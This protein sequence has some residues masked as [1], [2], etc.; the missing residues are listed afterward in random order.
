[1]TDLTI[2]GLVVPGIAVSA[3]GAVLA[4]AW[5]FAA[6]RELARL[7]ARLG[8]A[9]TVLGAVHPHR[10]DAAVTLWRETAAF[11]RA[12][13]DLL[14]PFEELALEEDAPRGARREAFL[15]HEERLARELAA[16]FPALMRA[17]ASAECF[18]TADGGR[19]V[20]ALTDAYG[21]AHARYW[22]SRFAE[23]RDE[24]REAMA[25]ARARFAAARAL[26]TEVLAHVREVLRSDVV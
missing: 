8:A 19:A 22:E 14:A 23:D 26:R 4:A 24:Q 18:F 9:G 11:E 12:L 2:A 13:D 6:Q 25:A 3:A 16:M 1:M 20:R 17:A 15:R 5:S 7:Q 21:E 10:V